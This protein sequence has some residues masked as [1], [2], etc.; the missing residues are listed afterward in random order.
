MIQ[1]TLVIIKPDAILR[2]VLNDSNDTENGIKERYLGVGLRI[3]REARVAVSLAKA[4]IF[5]QGHAQEK[6]FEGA[7]LAMASGMNLILEIEGEDAIS[8]VRRM[9]GA[10]NPSKAEPG[11]IRRDFLSAGGPFNM[12]HGSDSEESAEREIALMFD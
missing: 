4:K 8:V 6:F 7:V 10:T 2:D 12:V 11:T 3:V 1:R 9:N 5:H